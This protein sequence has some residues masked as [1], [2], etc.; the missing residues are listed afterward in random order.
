MGHAID[1]IVLWIH[2]V[3]AMFFVG[4]SLFVWLVLVPASFR[5]TS[6]EAART[7]MVATIA[8]H[9]GR[10]VSWDFLIVI[11]SG[12]Y[13]AFRYLPAFRAL[14]V[15][16]EGA[17]LLIK[18]ILVILLLVSVL[19]HDVYFSRRISRLADS[20]RDEELRTIRKSSRVV[21]MLSV[22][23]MLA[24]LVMVILMQMSD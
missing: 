22:A 15:T 20:G 18:M 13:N 4:G 21:S 10:I 1:G 16:R 2:L 12:I 24:V 9:F 14:F 19:V 8:R 3:T 6:D 17:L 7:K 23:F 11:A 5:L